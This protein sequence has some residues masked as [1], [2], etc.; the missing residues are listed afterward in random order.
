MNVFGSR[1]VYIE[2]V[3][4]ALKRA[5]TSYNLLA[6]IK[7]LEVLTRRLSHL[8]TSGQKSTTDG[9]YRLSVGIS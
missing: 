5:L 4:R 7:K 1:K 8:F 6:S 3:G 9:L 2:N